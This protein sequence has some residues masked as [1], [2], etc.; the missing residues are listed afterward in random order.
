MRR[1]FFSIAYLTAI[2]ST[3]LLS[4]SKSSSTTNTQ[5]QLSYKVT[6]NNYTPLTSV[7]Y[8]DTSYAPVTGSASDSTSGWSKTYTVPASFSAQLS[9]QGI[10]STSA[11]L[12]YTLEIDEDGAIKTKVQ[13]S[14][15]KFTSFNT[16]IGAT[17]Q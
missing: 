6:A 12:Y 8:V 9:V 7:S 5:H 17:I 11:T 2:I 16:Q 15:A 10:N 14:A 1:T 13:D 3:C 4:C